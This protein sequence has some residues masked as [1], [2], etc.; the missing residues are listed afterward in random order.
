MGELNSNCSCIPQP[1][2][3][4]RHWGRIWITW[5][6]Y[7]IERVRHCW[8]YEGY[9][10]AWKQSFHLYRLWEEKVV[11]WNLSCHQK[12]LF[13]ALIIQ[14]ITFDNITLS[15]P[16]MNKYKG[17]ERIEISARGF[18]G[19]MFL[20]RLMTTPA[21]VIEYFSCHKDWARHVSI[22]CHPHLKS[23]QEYSKEQPRNVY[24]D[25]II[26]QLQITSPSVAVVTPLKTSHWCSC[27]SRRWICLK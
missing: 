23:G 12:Y 13:S 7:L 11:Y 15:K 2:R 5:K 27:I 1:K 9:K 20:K 18:M 17:L 26:C 6:E 25:N 22:T 19:K 24:C 3:D 16:S 14:K 10:N 8:S 4:L 21:C